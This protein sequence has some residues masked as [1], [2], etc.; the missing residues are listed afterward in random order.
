MMVNLENADYGANC[1]IRMNPLV[2][3]YY[4]MPA[5]MEAKNKTKA[6]MVD[7]HFQRVVGD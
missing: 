4:P 6:A 3:G 2:N 1:L 5:K 7:R